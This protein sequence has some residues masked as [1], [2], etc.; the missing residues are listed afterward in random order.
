MK[1]HENLYSGESIRP[2]LKRIRWKV[3]HNAGQL[4]VYV[5]TLASNEKNLLD[6]YPANT[7]LWHYFYK[8]SILIVGIA[9]S[10]EEAVE[11]ACQIVT[12]VYQDTGSFNVR[13]YIEEHDG[14]N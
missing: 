11:L 8:S 14:K 7:M 9:G 12:Q 3:N 5:I 2:R 10:H 1:W 13:S 4:R 6:I